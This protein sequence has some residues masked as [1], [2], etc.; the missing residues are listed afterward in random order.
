MKRDWT[1]ATRRPSGLPRLKDRSFYIGGGVPYN[2]WKWKMFDAYFIG[3]THGV[4]I[5]IIVGGLA[6]W[7]A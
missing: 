7:V 3:F 2:R 4:G 1:R 6:I 5:T